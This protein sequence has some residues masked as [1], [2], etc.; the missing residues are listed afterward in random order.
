MELSDTYGTY[1]S[2]LQKAK[3]NLDSSRIN[4][5]STKINLEKNITDVKTNLDKLNTD[6]QNALNDS[7]LTYES[8]NEN[9]TETN[10][11]DTTSK[12]SMSLE[13]ANKDLEKA[14]FDLENLKRNNN[15]TKIWF[16]SSTKNIILS[17]SKSTSDI[18]L[19]ADK[20]LWVTNEYKNQNDDFEIYLWAKNSS[21][22]NNVENELLKLF[23][24]KKEIETLKNTEITESNLLEILQKTYDYHLILDNFIVLIKDVLNNSIATTT[25][26]QATIDWQNATFGWY[27]SV[28]QWNLSGLTSLKTQIEAF[29]ASYKNS[30]LSVEKSIDI[31]TRQIEILK[32]DL[33]T[34]QDNAKRNLSKTEIA[35]N[36]NLLTL[37]TAIK[38]TKATLDNLETTKSNTLKNLENQLNQA[39]LSFNDALSEVAKLQI[40]A[41]ISWKMWKVNVSIWQDVSMWTQLFNI[42]SWDLKQEVNIGLTLEELKYTKLFDKVQVIHNWEKVEWTI[43]TISSSAWANLLYNVKIILDKSIGQTWEL[44]TVIFI[45][46]ENNK[47]INESL[48][49]PVNIV[50]VIWNWSW[51]LYLF[52]ENKVVKKQ[53]EIW[54]VI[55]WKIE[56][57]TRLNN[58]EK[59]ITNDLTN[60]NENKH[61]LKVK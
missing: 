42:I 50:E 53:I 20:L 47:D 9:I 57:K 60:Y 35:V 15:Q 36:S 31:A 40:K 38:N 6:Y 29:F 43:S 5:D 56:L 7:T 28:I 13:K 27:Q 8:I 18:I 59:I 54:K 12:A 4:Y 41:P 25:F 26:T 58:D 39:Q 49:I 52:S 34:A 1:N 10:L 17:L 24:L 51:N 48:F 19:S 3:I 32:K 37:E 21:L 30:E 2:M 33:Q 46:K 22:K 23:S 11:E 14:K 44:V 45:N 16:Q 61:N 55:D